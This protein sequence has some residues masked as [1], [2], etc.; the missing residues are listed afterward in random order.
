MAH[1]KDFQIKVQ[2]TS[3][4]VTVS[5][6][7]HPPVTKEFTNPAPNR[8]LNSKTL[9]WLAW[10]AMYT[11]MSA[12]L[13]IAFD[14]ITKRVDAARRAREAIEAAKN[15]PPPAKTKSKGKK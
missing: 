7:D 5:V 1:V 3:T 11:P 4:T 2:M 10:L 12:A 14:D 13:V 15:A 9:A 8:L 6:D